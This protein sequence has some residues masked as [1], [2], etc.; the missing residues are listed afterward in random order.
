MGH[1]HVNLPGRL[2]LRVGQGGDEA[3]LIDL[4]VKIPWGAWLPASASASPAARAAAARESAAAGETTAAP[5]RE[6]APSSADEPP[7]VT[8]PSARA[9]EDAPRSPEEYEKPH[10]EEKDAEN[11]AERVLVHLA[12]SVHHR[13]SCPFV[14]ILRGGDHRI[15]ARAEASGVIALLEVR[16]DLVLDDAFPLPQLPP[17][18]FAKRVLEP[19]PKNPSSLDI[20]SR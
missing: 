7:A 13:L 4:I 19:S 20:N 8:A 17:P 1:I 16:R 6:S 5:I 2:P 10:G 11:L 18:P 12:V 15:D 3:R 14:L 9:I